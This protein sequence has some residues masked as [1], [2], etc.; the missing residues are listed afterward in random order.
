[1]YLFVPATGQE[2]RRLHAFN[3]CR[4]AGVFSFWFPLFSAVCLHPSSFV[5]TF[6][7]HAAHRRVSWTQ[8]CVDELSEATGVSWSH[9]SDIEI[10]SFEW[11]RL[12]YSLP[13]SRA[14][15]NL[16]HSGFIP[17]LG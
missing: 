2:M 5:C 13:G 4:A 3:S 8:T 17:G 1:M 7:L 16:C 14:C 11:Q 12:Q 15:L 6:V 9:S 10:G